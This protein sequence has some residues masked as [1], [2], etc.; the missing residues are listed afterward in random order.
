[1]LLES[2]RARPCPTCSVC[3]SRGESIYRDL[4]DV[5]FGAPGSWSISRCT[6]EQCGLLWLDPQPDPEDIGLAYAN[7]YTHS[8]SANGA[9]LPRTIVRNV[10]GAVL[11]AR[12]G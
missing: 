7:Y 10:R 3:G 12:L 6:N 4:N 11:R 5:L 2:I 1:M 9:S 8:T